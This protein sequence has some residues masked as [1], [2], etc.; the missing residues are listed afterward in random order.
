ML[1]VPLTKEK[2]FLEAHMK[3]RPLDFATEGIF[4][5]GLAQGPK[6][7]DESIAQGWGA[8]ARAATILSKDTLDS[9]AMVAVVDEMKCRGCGRC[10]E[11]CDYKAPEVKLR[12][13][14]RLAA[15]INEALC[16]GCGKCSTRCCSGAITMRHFD[17]RQVEM[18]LEA[19]LMEPEEG[20]G[21]SEA[22]T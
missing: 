15:R 21:K 6:F 17:S 9:E 2:F 1:K 10:E 5:C 20:K 22:G 4:V 7:I 19:A 8:A 16:K 14:G 13:N 18:M 3:L 12:E 11:G